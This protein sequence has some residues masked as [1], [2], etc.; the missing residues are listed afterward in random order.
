MPLNVAMP[1]DKS[2]PTMLLCEFFFLITITFLPC[3]KLTRIPIQGFIGTGDRTS[4]KRRQ[5]AGGRFVS[6]SAKCMGR[7][8]GEVVRA[9]REFAFHQRSDSAP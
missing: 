7:A 6:R 9:V 1:A 5:V 4:V 3:E 8:A 2:Q